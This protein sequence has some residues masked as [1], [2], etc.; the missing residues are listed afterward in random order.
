MVIPHNLSV[1]TLN[2][3]MDMHKYFLNYGIIS[4]R[5]WQNEKPNCD[6]FTKHHDV[7]IQHKHRQKRKESNTDC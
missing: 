7:P 6:E 4:I 3:H 5:N 2:I 1:L